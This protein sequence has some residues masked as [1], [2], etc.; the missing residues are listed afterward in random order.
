MNRTT[1][2]A[3]SATVAIV[4]VAVAGGYLVDKL[5]ADQARLA[6][7]TPAPASNPDA[8]KP[9]LETATT[10]PHGVT[11]AVSVA[12]PPPSTATSPVLTGTLPDRAMVALSGTVTHKK[13]N[14]L[15]VKDGARVTQVV[16]SEDI[17]R[18][19]EMSGFTRTVDKIGVGQPVTIYGRVR[20]GDGDT[21]VYADAIYDPS[22]RTLYKLNDKPVGDKPAAQL[23]T[24]DLNAQYAPMSKLT[25]A[26]V[27]TPKITVTKTSIIKD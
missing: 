10:A 2:L 26:K 23:T 24:A 16:V 7:Q 15:T 17:P 5:P 19:R 3:A 1:L 20:S 13:G 11:G 18:P 25:V 21:K 6:M 4:A 27:G 9:A 12:R 14:T 8:L 22:I